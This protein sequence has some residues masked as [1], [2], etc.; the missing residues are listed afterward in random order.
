MYLGYRGWIKKVLYPRGA[1]KVRVSSMQQ[2]EWKSWIESCLSACGWTSN[3]AFSIRGQ[4]CGH[5]CAPVLACRNF[6]LYQILCETPEEPRHSVSDLLGQDFSDSP[7]SI[8]LSARA[9]R[10]EATCVSHTPWCVF[11][12][13]F[14]YSPG[15]TRHNSVKLDSRLDV[16]MFGLGGD[17]SIHETG[18]WCSGRINTSPGE[19]RQWKYFCKRCQS[20][21]CTHMSRAV[22]AYFKAE[23][24]LP[25]PTQ[26]HHV[27]GHPAPAPG[28]HP[29]PGQLMWASLGER[30]P[31]KADLTSV[32]RAWSALA[33]LTGFGN[34]A[35]GSRARLDILKQH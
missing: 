25:L 26:A 1:A 31:Q 13:Q 30:V 15:I 23:V 17:F 33:L 14:V 28:A 27:R 19:P 18:F 4:G 24:Y 20:S 6:P 29:S 2:R 32:G 10:K 35:G 7:V 34:G 8:E 21:S 5:I 9:C 12:I 16:L 22:W 11:S 3:E